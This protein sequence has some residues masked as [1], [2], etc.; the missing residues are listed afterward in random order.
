MSVYWYLPPGSR[1]V[2]LLETVTGALPV[3]RPPSQDA[4]S[5]VPFTS[6]SKKQAEIVNSSGF[7]TMPSTVAPTW[8]TLDEAPVVTVGAGKVSRTATLLSLGANTS[9]PVAVPYTA[10][11]AAP[12]LKPSL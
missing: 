6:Y 4:F 7:S 9:V 10:S 12:P 1:P 8:F 3:G 2:S 11:R 5:L